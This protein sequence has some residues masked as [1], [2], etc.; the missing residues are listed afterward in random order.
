MS[1]SERYSPKEVEQG[2]YNWWKEQNLFKAEDRSTK[3]PFSIILPPPNVTGSLHIGH[4]LGSTLQDILVRWKR[5]SG[6][7]VLWMPGTDHAGIATQTV[8]EKQLA[9]DK[10]TRHQLGREKFLEKV[11]EWKESHGNQIVKQMERL[12]LSC[13]WQRFIF[14]LDPSVSEAV[15]KSFVSLYEKKWIYKGLR[16][17]NWSTKLQSAVSDLEVEHKDVKGSLWHIKYL[18]DNGKN[19]LEVATTRPETLL[20][21]MAVAVHPEDSRYKNLVGKKVKLPLVNREI[22]ILADEYVSKDFGS[23]VVKITPAHDFND[24][25]VGRRH[26]L[27]SMNILNKD[28]SLNDRAGVYKGLTVIEARKKV[29]EDLKSQG[30]LIKEE[31]HTHSV[32]HCSRTGCVIEPF[33]SEQWFVKTKELAILARRVVESGSISFEP[34]LWTK[35]YLHWM[36]NIEDWCI[37]R[38]L[39]WGHRIPAWNCEECEHITV[40]EEDLTQCKNCKS[41]KIKQD[42]DVLDTWFSSALWPFSTMGW[43]NKTETQETFY[44]TDVLVTGHDI[45][46]FWVARMIMMGMEFKKDIPFRTVYL[47]GLVRDSQGRKMSKSLNNSIDPIDV[48]EKYGADALRLSLASQ[49]SGRDLKM[50]FQHIESSRNFINKV[51]NSA[52]FTLSVLEGKDLKSPLKSSDLTAI[53]SWIICKLKKCEAQVHSQMTRFR[54]ADAT[55]VLYSFIWNDFCDWYLELAKPI[56]YGSGKTVSSHKVLF[57]VLR[58]ILK[59]LHPF[60]PFVTESIYQKLPQVK[61]SL[62]IESY[63]TEE[64]D[65]EFLS[66]ASKDEALEIDTLCSVIASIRNIRGENR[67]P[68]K[69]KITGFVCSEGASF[70]KSLKKNEEM[71]K[72]LAGLKDCSFQPPKSLA[73]SAVSVVKTEGSPI[74]VI[75]PLEGLVNFNKEVDRLKKQLEKLEKEKK[76]I[77]T[78]LSQKSFVENAPKDVVAKNKEDLSKLEEEMKSQKESLSRFL[79]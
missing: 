72:D 15:K 44:P 23:G 58:R 47:T 76:Q 35:T 53:D 77:E 19:F 8:V 67:I 57:E 11:W 26:S 30:L 16:L 3:P 42:E 70:I 14:T 7:N 69:A 62:M 50:S 17:I 21:D 78:R 32:G 64:S 60:T 28:G 45:I 61:G 36:N 46:F 74:Q 27:E 59:L 49:S 20:G 51:W 34:A 66:L 68:L 48:I 79:G 9:K 31:K 10:T 6:F 29:L 71:L 75:I 13:D 41:E 22:P 2:L 1:L 40:S 65:S 37:S 73:K 43:P 4:A 25:E 55:Q 39:W 24:Y 52:R 63:P 18:L 54:F 5:M 12:G 56:V 38:Q 33:L